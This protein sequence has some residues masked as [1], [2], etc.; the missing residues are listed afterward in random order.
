[1]EGESGRGRGRG[2]V[3]REDRTQLR[4]PFGKPVVSGW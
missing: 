1:M 3:N 4:R 2:F